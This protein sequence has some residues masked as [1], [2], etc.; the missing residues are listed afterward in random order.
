M[1][2]WVI[3]SL[4]SV[5]YSWSLP[6]RRYATI[7]G[8]RPLRHPP[9][10]VGRERLAGRRRR[11]H[12]PPA[13]PAP[14]HEPPAEP[15]VGDHHTQRRQQVPEL[16]QQPPPAVPVLHVG[17]RHPR[18]PDQPERIDRSA[19]LPADRL[20]SPVVP[21]VAAPAGGPHRLTVDPAGAGHRRQPGLQPALPAE[22]RVDLLPGAVEPPR[23]EVPVRGLPRREVVRQRPPRRPGL[24]VVE[25]GVA[26]LPQV[27][28]RPAAVGRAGLRPGQEPPQPPPLLVGQVGRGRFALPGRR[29]YPTRST[30]S[31]YPVRQSPDARARRPGAGRSSTARFARSPRAGGSATRCP[32]ADSTAARPGGT[33]TARPE[34]PAA[35]S[36]AR[37]GRGP[38]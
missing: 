2:A 19:P 38:G 27:G 29:R 1:A 20:F 28:R 16:A 32:A 34:S 31:R 7:P 24:Q 23:P 6:S 18:R 9:P 30:V 21:A 8:E 14:R 17:G 13:P 22:F 36:T 37:A 4:V 35:G 26:H 3:A 10:G 11:G 33:R 5:R 15:A 12:P 25:D